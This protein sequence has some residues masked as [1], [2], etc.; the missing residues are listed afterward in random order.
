VQFL[1]STG[2]RDCGSSTV[3]V[4]ALTDALAASLKEADLHFVSAND[5]LYSKL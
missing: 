2:S 5:A 3:S 4:S 1:D